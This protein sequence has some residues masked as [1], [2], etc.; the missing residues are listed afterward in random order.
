MRVDRTI[1]KALNHE[2][3]FAC[4][5]YLSWCRLD[6]KAIDCQQRELFE[7]NF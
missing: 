3:L 7:E 1:V 4:A 5:N 2:D 6:A